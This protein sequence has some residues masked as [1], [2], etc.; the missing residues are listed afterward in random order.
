MCIICYVQGK[1]SR[2]C[3]ASNVVPVHFSPA[4]EAVSRS[5]MIFPTHRDLSRS[6]CIQKHDPRVPRTPVGLSKNVYTFL[7]CIVLESLQPRPGVTV[8]SLPPSVAPLGGPGDDR[9]TTGN[10]LS[11]FKRSAVRRC[12]VWNWWTMS[13]VVRR[14]DAIDAIFAAVCMFIFL[15]W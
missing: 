1:R 12:V 14:V 3:S 13:G 6:R 10:A 2:C 15:L 9:E 11:V 5:E 7:F 4:L 8:A